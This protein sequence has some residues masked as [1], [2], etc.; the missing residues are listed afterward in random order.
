MASI[1]KTVNITWQGVKYE[2]TPSFALINYVENNGVSI[3]GIAAELGTNAF[4]ITNVARM[5]CLFLRSEGAEVDD[6]AVYQEMTKSTDTVASSLLIAADLVNACF[7]QNQ[8][9][10][11]AAKSAKPSKKKTSR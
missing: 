10:E 2:I 9:T 3:A 6:E 11:E 4:K 5:V 8:T 7:P 1:Y